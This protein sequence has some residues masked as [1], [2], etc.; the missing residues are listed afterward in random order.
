MARYLQAQGYRVVP[1]NPMLER[2]LG[3]R[4]YPSVAAIPGEISLDIVDVFR[5]SEEV[6]PVAEHAISRRVPVLWMQL[7][8][9]NPEA[10]A[11]ARAADLTVFS[12]R[13][14]M[15]DHRRL[16]VPPRVARS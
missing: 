12:D 16:K 4:S 10:S 5:R 15:Q 1:V 14:I 13:C 9:E 3:E 7:G 8:V 2:V 6:P 11:R